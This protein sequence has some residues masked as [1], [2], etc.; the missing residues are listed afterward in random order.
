MCNIL[1]HASVIPDH[2]LQG[3]FGRRIRGFWTT[4]LK[5]TLAIQAALDAIPKST[6][7]RPITYLSPSLPFV[8]AMN[9]ERK[10]HIMSIL[11][12][13]PDSFSDGGALSPDNL[14]TITN[15]VKSHISS[16]ATILDIGGQ[17]TRPHAELLS[18]DEELARILPILRHIKHNIPEARNV[19][20]SIDTFHAGVVRACA[21]EDLFDIVNDVSAGT[22]DPEMLRTV[23]QVRKTI[24]LMHMRGTPAT[25]NKLTSYPDG[26]LST[27]RT[28]LA[29]RVESALDAGVPPWRIMLDPGIGFAK[30]MDQNLL[31]LKAGV[32]PLRLREKALQKLPW[33]VGT[34][35]KGFI[36]K[37]TG[38]KEANER[39]WGTAACVTAAI[40]GGADVVRVHD[41]AEMSGV[42]KMADSI[43]RKW[44]K[45][46]GAPRDDPENE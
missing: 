18:P 10:T 35:R 26:L 40:A 6:P 9:P 13:T 15:T 29:A 27:V 31:L 16:G 1:N 19:A 24:I 32:K 2:T 22:M 41:V 25:M 30:T 45:D 3:T 11:N 39:A 14:S 23:A 43:W 28:E 4:P 5:G 21:D 8:Q 42:V 36:G 33:V 17:S 12:I 34:S 46:E 7:M 38:V 44:F 37:I 20:I